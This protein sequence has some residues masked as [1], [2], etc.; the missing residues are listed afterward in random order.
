[1][2]PTT[3]VP[4]V[5]ADRSDESTVNVPP[6]PATEIDLLPFGF[7]VTVP[8]PAPIVPENAT[9]LAVMVTA[10]L[11]VLMDLVEALVTLPVPS[12]VIVTPVVPVTFWLSVTEPLEPEDV[13]KTTALPEML[14]EVV[15]VPLAVSVSVP[16]VEVIRPLVPRVAEPPVVVTE[17]S[18]PTE[19]AASVSAPAFVR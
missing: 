15:M 12:V 18:P 14:L 9:S 2:V 19:E 8:V 4:A 5:I 1:M 17:K 3:R 13:V 6:A 11:V 7:S 10:E 16:L